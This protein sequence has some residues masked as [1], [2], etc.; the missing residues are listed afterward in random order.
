MCVFIYVMIVFAIGPGD[1]CLFP[2]RDILKTKKRVNIDA[3]LLDIQHYKV[4]FDSNVE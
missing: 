4:L 2:G 3:A 1:R